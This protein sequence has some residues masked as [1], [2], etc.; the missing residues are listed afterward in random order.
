MKTISIRLGEHAYP[1]FVTPNLGNT[2][3]ALAVLKETVGNRSCLV[4]TDSNVAPLYLNAACEFLEQ[5]G[6]THIATATIPAGEQNKTLS[7]V[8]RL[9]HH[10]VSGK[11]DRRS[12]IVAVG[13]GVVGDLAGFVAA[14]YQRGIGF[15]QA[16]T[17]LLG[18]V[19]S[20][21]G[22]KVGVDLPEG[23]NLV[24]AFHQ[25][26]LVLIGMRC[27]ST[28]PERE[29]KCGLAEVVKYGMIMDEAFFARLETQADAILAHD[30]AVL[31]EVI[32]RCC[33][34]KGDVVEQDERESGLR[35]ILNYGH[36]FGHALETLGG[37][38]VLSHGEA[39]AIGMR[40]AARMAVLLGRITPEVEARQEALLSKFGLG[41][42]PAALK[43]ITAPHLLMTM[44]LDKKSRSGKLRLV[45][46]SR[47]G[48]CETVEIAQETQVLQAIEAI[49]R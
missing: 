39:V 33:R 4:V 38:S 6:A 28:L 24:G 2:S 36:T 26:Q 11:M 15:I 13:G 48:H 25:P 21:V 1:I 42:V 44:R 34:L 31:A 14:T 30:P 10:A 20:S 37:Y 47:I 27:L 49:L 23:K 8:E 17:T 9:Y 12:V 41:A 46:P 35:E 45:L 16:P 19:D 22:G 3:E 43:D 32:A 29:W 7:T 5:A 40:M 18:M